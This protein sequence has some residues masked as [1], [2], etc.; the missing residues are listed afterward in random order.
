MKL[1]R[2]LVIKLSP[3]VEAARGEPLVEPFFELLEHSPQRLLL[4]SSY[5]E[6]DFDRE[7]RRVLRDSV[8]VADFASIRSVDLDVFP[9][10]RGA[11][12]WSVTL[13]RSFLDRITV[14]RGYDDGE[15]SVLGAKLSRV[16]GC[17]V[18]SLS[19]PR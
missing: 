18:I 10:G 16:I 7:G 14:A 19:G 6:F 9:G 5:G 17:K 12:S 11:R 15:V 3:L 4:R 2:N 1:P 13:Y 8:A